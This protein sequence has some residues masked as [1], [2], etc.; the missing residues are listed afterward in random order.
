MSAIDLSNLRDPIEPG[1]GN[2]S[3]VITGFDVN[4]GVIVSQV[5]DISSGTIG[6]AVGIPTLSNWALIG[7]FLLMILMTLRIRRPFG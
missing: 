6:P 4:G 7:L 5:L 3:I 2:F 1:F